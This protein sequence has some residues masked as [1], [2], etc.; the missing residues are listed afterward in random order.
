MGGRQRRTDPAYGHIYDHFAVDFEYPTGA[1]V[2]SMCRQIDGCANDVSEQFAG[3]RGRTNARNAIQGPNAWRYEA[4][5]LA[6]QA[7]S[8]DSTDSPRATNNPYVLEH[9][10]LIASI[11]AGAPLNEGKQVAQSTLTAI[12]GREAAYTGQVITWDELLNGNQNLM[13]PSIAFGPLETPGVPTPGI[14]KVSRG[15]GDP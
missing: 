7:A 1:R 4:P 2:M 12:M 13:P 14:T 9:V 8:T 5:M 10:N 11:R 15:W 6:G 3:T